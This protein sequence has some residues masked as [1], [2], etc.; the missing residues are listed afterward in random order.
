M[1]HPSRHQLV[2]IAAVLQVCL[3]FQFRGREAWEEIALAAPFPSLPPDSRLLVLE[4][5]A[6][7]LVLLALLPLLLVLMLLVLVLLLLSP[8]TRLVKKLVVVLMFD[9]LD[10]SPVK[11]VFEKPP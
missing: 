3:H 1:L 7:S 4:L 10:G 6:P 8:F 5:L 2:L 9:R 11:P